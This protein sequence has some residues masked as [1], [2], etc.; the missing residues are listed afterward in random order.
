MDDSRA[1]PHALLGYLYGLIKEWDK[2]IAEGE[3]GLALNP[4]GADVKYWYAVTLTFAGRPKE[5][6]LLFE[7]AIR[8]NPFGP[9][10]YFLSY[11]HALLYVDR[12]DEAVS[13]YKKAL[14]R[15]PNN[16]LRL[17]RKLQ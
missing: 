3:K 13:A 17:P 6:I 5:A 14:Q 7:K 9:S 4:S 8:L 16:F 2:A 15:E 1:E 12:F 11:G 10:R